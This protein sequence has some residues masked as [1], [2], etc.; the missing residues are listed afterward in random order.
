MDWIKKIDIIISTRNRAKELLLTI[1]RMS[2]M[3]FSQD[4]FY[5]IDDASTDGTFEVLQ[6]EFPGVKMKHNKVSQGYIK[7]RNILM[8]WT[9]REFIMSLDDDSHI[10]SKGDLI[11]ALSILTSNDKY[12]IFHFR[13]FHQLREPPARETLDSEIRIVKSYIGCGH[14]IKREVLKSVGLYR[15]FFGFYCEEIDYSIRA[16]RL[17]YYV[18]TKN[19]LVV[20]HRVDLEVRESQKKSKVS[21]GIYGRSWR[22]THIYSNNLLVVSLHY[23]LLISWLY[24][25]VKVCRQG[26]SLIVDECDFSGMTQGIKRYIQLRSSVGLAID[27]MSIVE[28][29]NWSKIPHYIIARKGHC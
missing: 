7:N 21:K 16:F 8:E 22:N 3:G 4:Q 15:E 11:E 17:G 28:F 18:V 29:Y 25:S 1:K 10:R 23:P 19:D 12:G 27:R 13:P 5:V 24:L 9:S 2:E 6:K 26:Y 20:H 14:I